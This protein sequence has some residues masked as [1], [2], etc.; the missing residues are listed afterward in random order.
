MATCQPARLEALAVKGRQSKQIRVHPAL[1]VK[2]DG[3]D[4]AISV[5]KQF[6]IK[7][8]I[9]NIKAYLLLL[10]M[11]GRRENIF[12]PLS[13]SGIILTWTNKPNRKTVDV[14]LSP[15]VDLGS[16]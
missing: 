10:L 11:L 3:F 4:R 6:E 7:G 16:L 15:L 8:R 9:S 1:K 2:R 5:F 14:L 12:R 13:P